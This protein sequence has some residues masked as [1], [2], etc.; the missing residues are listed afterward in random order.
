MLDL[1][2]NYVAT[3]VFLSQ[4]YFVKPGLKP[5]KNSGKNIFQTVF[6]LNTKSVELSA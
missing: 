6:Y 3:T 1:M 5:A 2:N 4:L